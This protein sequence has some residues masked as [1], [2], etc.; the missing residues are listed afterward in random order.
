MEG[1]SALRL[2]AIEPCL[3]VVR[4]ASNSASGSKL[5]ELEEELKDLKAQKSAEL[6]RE[7]GARDLIL[8]E[9]NKDL[10]RV[11]AAITALSSGELQFTVSASATQ[12][13]LV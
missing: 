1:V 12:S 2:S 8:R 13:S 10:D 4:M 9:L 11:Q 7:E 6:K 5:A 3:F